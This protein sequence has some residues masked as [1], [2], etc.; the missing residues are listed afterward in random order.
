MSITLCVNLTEVIT[1]VTRRSLMALR[2]ARVIHIRSGQLR[3]QD[4]SVSTAYA[5]NH[6]T[7]Y[8]TLSL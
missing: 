8:S 4:I 3:I 7:L 5:V 6:S 1:K 2:A